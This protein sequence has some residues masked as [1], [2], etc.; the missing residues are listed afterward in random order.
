MIV[1]IGNLWH[2]ERNQRK[3]GVN[4]EKFQCRSYITYAGIYKTIFFYILHMPIYV[5][6]CISECLWASGVEN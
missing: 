1:Y 3:K 4:L 2:L 5:C 6:I